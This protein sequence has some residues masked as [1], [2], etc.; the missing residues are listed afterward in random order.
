[1]IWRYFWVV[2]A[3]AFAGLSLIALML[4]DLPASIGFSAMAVA[5]WA[6]ARVESL[7]GGE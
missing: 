6:H 1:M 7:E 4:G 5:L 3:N 2:M